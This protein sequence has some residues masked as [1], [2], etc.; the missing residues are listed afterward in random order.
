MNVIE[1][2]DLNIERLTYQQEISES[3]NSTIDL[4]KIAFKYHTKWTILS[5]AESMWDCAF[6]F[7]LTSNLFS[8]FSRC[9][10]RA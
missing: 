6:N 9:I 10:Y 5:S 2:D 7:S 1:F 4:H 8:D 3:K